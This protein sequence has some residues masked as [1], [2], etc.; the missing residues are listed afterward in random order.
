MK[1]TIITTLLAS[2]ISLAAATRSFVDSH[3]DA[4]LV[5]RQQNQPCYPFIMN[6]TMGVNSTKYGNMN[7]SDAVGMAANLLGSNG[8]N[9]NMPVTN[10][11]SLITSSSPPISCNQV[12]KLDIK[13]IITG[14]W[15]T[16]TQSQL[17]LNAI[18]GVST[19]QMS[20]TMTPWCTNTKSDYMPQ[21]QGSSYFSA[22]LW[23]SCG[24]D[25]AWLTLSFDNQVEHTTLDG[26]DA[27]AAGVATDAI[28]DF[29]ILPEATLGVAFPLGGILAAIVAFA[30]A[31]ADGDL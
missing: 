11:S 31:L 2:F 12:G 9:T 30:C 27:T 21:F 14:L 7:I 5:A 28:W 8:P 26:C 25:V 20:T 23:D 16:P 24:H 3:I 10:T 6:V 4:P 1:S 13:L 18:R 19:S 17:L 15:S 22:A 29:L